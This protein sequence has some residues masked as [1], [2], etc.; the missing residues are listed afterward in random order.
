MKKETKAALKT[1]IIYPGVGHFH[2]NKYLIGIIF[3]SVFS[4]FLL[5]TLQDIFAIA[6]CT[7]NDIVSGKVPFSIISILKLAHTPSAH[8]A[9]LAEYKYVPLMI[10]IW[11]LSVADAYRLGKLQN[12]N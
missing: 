2:L 10:V 9:I 11:L 5:L 1:A 7:A 4:A 8:C 3:M 6:Q 12:H